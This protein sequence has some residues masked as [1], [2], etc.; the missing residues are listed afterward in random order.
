MGEGFEWAGGE[1]EGNKKA[2][3]LNLNISIGHGDGQYT[4]AWK[5]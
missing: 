3:N 5:I 4:A 2:Q 1:S